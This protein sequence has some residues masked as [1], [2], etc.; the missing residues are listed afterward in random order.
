[1]ARIA[2]LADVFDAL[3]TTRP[4]KKPWPLEEVIAYIEIQAGKQ[5]DPELIPAFKRALPQILLIRER[6]ADAHG[7]LEDI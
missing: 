1:M 4:Y 5:F 3:T 6:F 7:S 2:A